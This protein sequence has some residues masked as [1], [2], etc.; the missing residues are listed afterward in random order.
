MSKRAIISDIHGNLVALEAV[1]ADIKTQQVDEIVCLGDVC[2]YGPQPAECIKLMR[3]HVAWMLQGNHDEALFVEPKDFGKNARLAIQWQ[4]TILEPKPG[5]APEVVERWEWLKGLTPRRAERDVLF[6]HA[7]PRDPIYEYVLKEDFDNGFG[8]SQKAK[9]MFA[10]MDWL[11]F[12][13]HSHRPGVVAEDYQWRLPSEVPNGYIVSRGFKTIVNVGSVG[14]PRDGIPSACYCVFDYDPPENT[15]TTRVVKPIG[16][17][18]TLVLK[19]DDPAETKSDATAIPAV[20]GEADET[21]HGEE[22][23]VARDTVLLKLPRVRFRRVEYDI[24]AAQARFRAVP[25]L[26]D[27]LAQRLAVGM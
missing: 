25:E 12:C 27:S 3:E 23:Q 15:Q 10:A 4:R 16:S 13:G 5:C 7:S 6:V 8:P 17:A 2:G 18:H 9:D 26:P 20:K 11:C 24:A 21:R 1:L 14:Q 19:K 22:L